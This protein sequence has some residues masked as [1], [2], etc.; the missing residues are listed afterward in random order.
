MT[1]PDSI[2][3]T[4]VGPRDGLQNESVSIPVEAKIALVNRLAQS[5]V[6]EIE[7]SS[8]V[9]PQWV[10]QLA[11]AEAVFA[12][13]ER[14]SDVVYSALVPNLRGWERARRV[15]VDKIAV[16][17]TASETFARRNTNCTIAESLDR[18]APVVEAARADSIPVRGYVSCVV[19]CPYEGP[20]DAAAVREV[21]ASLLELGVDEIDLGDTIGVA[22][23]ED[24]DRLLDAVSSLVEPGELSLHLHDTGGSALACCRRAIERGVRRF[25]SSCGGLGGCPYAPGASG[26]L[27]TEDLVQLCRGEGIDCGVELDSIREASA[28]VASVIGRPLRTG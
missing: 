18:F 15:G 3:I 22:T 10:P 12:G 4:D 5:G 20:V 8:F 13:I 11:D 7:V 9:N 16:F 17:T 2:R 23:V 19:A 21:T 25:D 14:R 1:R 28:A 26:N 6:A 27:A 24:I